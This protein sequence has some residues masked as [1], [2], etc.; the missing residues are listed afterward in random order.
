MYEHKNGMIALFYWAIEHEEVNSWS[1]NNIA[2]NVYNSLRIQSL[3]LGNES[4]NK[5]STWNVT[6]HYY[7]IMPQLWLRSYEWRLQH[8]KGEYNDISI[9]AQI[10]RGS[11]LSTPENTN[12][13]QYTILRRIGCNTCTK[14]ENTIMSELLGSI[15]S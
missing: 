15:N 5:T 1:M 9:S 7:V 10:K 4:L 14:Y 3:K 12:T 13:T 2:L 11:K 6:K 8:T